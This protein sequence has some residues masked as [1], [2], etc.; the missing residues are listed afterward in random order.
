MNVL[1]ALYSPVSASFLR[2]RNAPGCMVPGKYVAS[3]QC[4][5]G[6]TPFVSRRGYR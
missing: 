3:G 1:I 6:S 5:C 2:S 4:L